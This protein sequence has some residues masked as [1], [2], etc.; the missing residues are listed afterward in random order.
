[1]I[2]VFFTGAF[3]G[4]GLIIAIGA[5]N[6]FVLALGLKRLHAFKAALVCAASDALL[7]LAGV[8]GLG[9]LI[10]ESQLATTI[11]A[12]GGAGEAGRQPEDVQ[13]AGR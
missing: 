4:A 8:A 2:D 7:I 11:A 13:A 12:L 9:S 10:A 5:Q 6:A 1:M 3:L